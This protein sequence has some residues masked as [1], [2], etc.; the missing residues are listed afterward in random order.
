MVSHRSV[1]K[2]LGQMIYLLDYFGDISI[3]HVSVSDII[4]LDIQ[5]GM[6]ITKNKSIARK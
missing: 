4:Q 6:G 5:K 2:I 3:P 1:R